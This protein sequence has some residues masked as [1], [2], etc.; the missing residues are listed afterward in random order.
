[1][2]TELLKSKLLEAAFNGSLTHADTSTWESTNIANI[3]DVKG[4]KRIPAGTSVQKEPTSHVYL[5]VTDMKNFTIVDDDIRYITDDLFEGIKKYTISEDD[6]YLTIA[7]TIG[8]VG[9]IP[10]KY[11]GMSLTENAVKLT[12]I[13]IDKSYLMYY[14]A[15]Y[16]VQ[17]RISLFVH[18]LAQPKLSI[19]NIRS[20]HIQYPS[21]EEQRKLVATLEEGFTYIDAVASAKHNLSISANLLRSKI[22]EDAF[23]GLLTSADV[24]KWEIAELGT[25]CKH[26]NGDRGKNYPSK[27]KLSH[28]GIP[29]ISALNLVN[30][31]VIDDDKLL[32]MSEEQFNKL[33]NGK[34][35]QRDFVLCIRG[36]VGKHG[37]YPF[38]KGAIASSLVIL[39]PVPD[40]LSL[41][42]LSYYFDSSLFREN[43]LEYINGTAQ[44]NLAAKELMKFRIPLPPLAEQ[45]RI[46]AKIEELFTQIDKIT[47]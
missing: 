25:A 12:N 38:E 44:P 8:R 17:R 2:N 18:Q 35:Q 43:L 3:A 46:V 30:N 42:W 10:H 24:N 5:R 26:Q 9:S 11:S 29:F 7:G 41:M 16:G 21:L 20:I 36:S 40:K 33:G 37:I 13:K 22:L 47:K 19:E 39:R 23:K 45:Q 15:S 6:L 4:G 14:L 31:T 32:K 27:K 34:L 1:M 28:C